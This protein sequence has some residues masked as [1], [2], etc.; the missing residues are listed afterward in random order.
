[1]EEISHFPRVMSFYAEP[2]GHDEKFVFHLIRKKIFKN[3]LKSSIIYRIIVG[4][5]HEDNLLKRD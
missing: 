2:C 5:Y 4:D 1:M 3:T